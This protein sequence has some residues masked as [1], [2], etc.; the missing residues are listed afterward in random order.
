V[1]ACPATGPKDAERRGIGDDFDRMKPFQF[2]IGT[3]GLT[4]RRSLV[5][6]ARLA[7]SIGFSHLTIHDHLTPQ[8]APIPVLTAV[9]MATE[10]L[11]LCPLVFNSDLR[12]PAVL[13]QDLATLDVLSEGRLVVGIGAGWNE[14]EYAAAGLA[15][16]PPRIRIDRMLE[17]VAILRGL[18]ADGPFSHAGRYYTI[19]GMDG[20]PKPVQRP[21]PPFLI[22]GTR[23]RVLRVAAREGDMVGLDLRQDRESLPDAFPARMDE[24]VGWVREAAGARFDDLDLS[25]LRLLGRVSVTDE[26]L[27]AAAAVARDIERRTGLAIPPG[28]ILESPYSLI[29]SVPDLVDKLRRGR[30]RW[31][32]NSILVGW[33]DDTDPRSLA[34]VIDQLAGT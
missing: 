13:A 10:R 18:F 2:M 26:P 20:Q 8:L 31:G 34:P 33:F 1:H 29:G 27:K 11:R 7:E 21:H 9:A 32:I 15:F 3:R 6:G 25:V 28:D 17:A 5:E 22:G 16:D 24:R 19:T 12:H 4:D 14:P 23:E 30:E